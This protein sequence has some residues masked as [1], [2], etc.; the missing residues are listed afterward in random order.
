MTR[1]WT[2]IP[3]ALAMLGTLTGPAA[4]Q[5]PA[6]SVFGTVAA[7]NLYRAED[8]SFGTKLN[9]GAGAGLE[10]KRLA[11]DVEVHRTV[12]LTPRR[13]EC[14][15]A[16]VACSGSAREGVLAATMVTANVSYSFGGAGVRPYVTGSVGVLR[17]EIVN[18]LTTV[19]GNAATLSEF[20]ER[21]TGLA[22]GLGIGLD[23]PLTGALSVRPEF[24]AYSSSALSR[25]NL[26]MH[27]GTVGLRY[28][29]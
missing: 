17:T 7:A 3:A 24:R 8:R 15:V 4:A 29:W 22:L 9:V 14:A 13:V 19:T 27:R 5:P 12:G 20:R 18:S 2:A 11:A 6:P 28:R 25:T 21:D 10:W 1:T 23:V 16:G 26:G